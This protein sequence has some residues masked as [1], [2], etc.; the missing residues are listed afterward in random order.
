MKL[1]IEVRNRKIKRDDSTKKR[2]FFG[3]KLGSYPHFTVSGPAGR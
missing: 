1:E 2:A 3:P